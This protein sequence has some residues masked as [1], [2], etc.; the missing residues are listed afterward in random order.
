MS[1]I[2][3]KNI[4]LGII[5]FIICFLYHQFIF[6]V[7]M[8]EVWSY[9]FSYNMSKHMIPYIDFTMVIPPLYPLIGSLF[10]KVFGAYLTS[11]NLYNS[12]IA[13][14]IFLLL[15]KR[16]NKLT[17]L[18]LP[19]LLSFIFSSYNLFSLFLFLLIIDID[20]KDI[21]HKDLL[22]GLLCA[23]SIFNK[24]TVGVFISIPIFIFSKNKKE[25]LIS[26]ISVC[27]L[28]LLYFLIN[29]N[30]Y[31]FFDYCLFG[32]F[33]F[34]DE[35]KFQNL[36]VI[37][38]ICYF[39]FLIY[40]FYK[41]IIK[42]DIKKNKELIYILCFQIISF[43]IL[44]IVHVGLGI[45]PLF[46]YIFERDN[47]Y[48]KVLSGYFYV[49]LLMVFIMTFS[50][51]LHMNNDHNLLNG[52]VFNND[53]DT[54][55]NMLNN[56]I[57]S[58][59]NEYEKYYFT[60]YAY[61]IKLMDNKDINKYD[62]TNNGN[63]GYNGDEKYINEVNEICKDTKCLFVLDDKLIGQNNIKITNYVKDNYNL[64]EIVGRFE[65]YIN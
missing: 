55:I 56:T 33:S 54:Q 28:F 42:G 6:R 7:N 14:L 52:R 39:I 34:A 58:N 50:F 64:K 40:L 1:K 5:I 8:D 44:N 15:Y 3:K 27:L 60:T 62:L 49:Q 24:Q 30:L 12:L 26:F 10:I 61:L 41:E 25:F 17:F 36:F 22:I 63:M 45:I 65:I 11:L 18:L 38:V 31:Q 46:P 13:T 51:N 2:N 59:Y 4:L 19:I 32:M 21:N 9:G 47:F 37:F 35:N 57:N 23:L 29:N 20:K 53:Y 48:L 16:L 43:P